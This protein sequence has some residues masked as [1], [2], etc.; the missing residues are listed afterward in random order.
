VLAVLGDYDDEQ[1]DEIWGG[2]DYRLDER[3][4]LDSLVG[5]AS[6]KIRMVSP[7]WIVSI[8]EGSI[9]LLLKVIESINLF[10]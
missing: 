2:I 4:P 1:D 7:P 9:I 10:H 8:R 3:L 6:K 5:F